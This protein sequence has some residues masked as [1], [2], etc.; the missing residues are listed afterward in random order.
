MKNKKILMYISIIILII[1][2]L[3]MG[4]IIINKKTDKKNNNMVE[5]IP[6][7]EISNEQLRNTVVTLYFANKDNLE[8][9]SEIRSIDSKELM[10]EPYK[11]IINLLID[12][13]KNNN[14]LKLIPENTSIN[15]IE[16]RGE[17]LYI[18]FSEDFIKEQTLGEKQEKLIIKSIVYT[19][20]ELTEINKIIVLIDGKE[21][22]S[23]PDEGIIFNEEFSRNNLF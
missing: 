9:T 1:I 16:K 10:E 6:E 18:D 11:K 8:L 5:Y 15:N 3:F 13:P 23:F 20:T 4:Y 19:L 17:V 12:G 14:L 21:N 22:C 7:Q 2:I